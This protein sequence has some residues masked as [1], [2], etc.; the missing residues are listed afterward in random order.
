MITIGSFSID[1]TAFP[2]GTIGL[3]VAAVI[4]VVVIVA[5][6]RKLIKAAITIAVLL[7][8]GA[9]VYLMLNGGD[10]ARL[11]QVVTDARSHGLTITPEQALDL[12]RGGSLTVTTPDGKTAA[13][14]LPDGATAP[15]VTIK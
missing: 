9:G 7:A 3:V 12:I 5:V 6:A 8:I 11:N 15:T 1:P 4:A 10:T 13:I 14:S 2:G